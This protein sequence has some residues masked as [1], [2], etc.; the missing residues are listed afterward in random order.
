MITSIMTSI[1]GKNYDRY[2]DYVQEYPGAVDTFEKNRK[3]N[4]NRKIAAAI[5]GLMFIGGTAFGVHKIREQGQQ[6]PTEVSDSFNDEDAEN[7]S[8]KFESNGGAIPSLEEIDENEASEIKESFAPLADNEALVLEN[9]GSI[10]NSLFSGDIEHL[11][12]VL[13]SK[14]ETTLGNVR[15]VGRISARGD[16]YYAAYLSAMPEEVQKYVADNNI[17]LSEIDGNKIIFINT[18]DAKII[19]VEL[20]QDQANADSVS[21]QVTEQVTF[22]QVA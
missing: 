1:N 3:R 20:S 18:I 4:R 19:T 5:L 11:S 17:E 9:G 16:S 12:T 15:E 21:T 10:R 22:D 13:L 7:S 2:P 14:E 8:P 6:Q